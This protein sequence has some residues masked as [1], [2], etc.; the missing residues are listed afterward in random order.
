MVLGTLILLLLKSVVA[1]PWSQ[2][3]RVSSEERQAFTQLWAKGW[4]RSWCTAL[5][6]GS[7]LCKQDE[8]GARGS[9]WAT[10]SSCASSPALH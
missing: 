9:A 2:P 4:E 10:L 1:L 5:D 8:K 7:P 6:P 3:A